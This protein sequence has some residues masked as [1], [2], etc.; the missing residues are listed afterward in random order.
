M[1]PSERIRKILG[2]L[3]ESR[4]SRLP[5]SGYYGDGGIKVPT[6]EDAILV[7]LDEEYEKKQEG[8]LMQVIC[9]RCGRYVPHIG[10]TN[11]CDDCFD[12]D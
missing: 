12:N 11:I 7:Y 5:S 10:P 2:Q 8:S 3:N 6:M 1:T 4:Q 9:D